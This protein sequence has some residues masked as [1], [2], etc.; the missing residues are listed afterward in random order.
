ME[1]AV[2]IAKNDHLNYCDQNFSRLYFG[3]E[4]CPHLLPAPGELAAVL[5]FARD[6]D[7][8]LVTPTSPTRSWAG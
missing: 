4:F 2:F 7:F 3:N 6:R 1:Y 8:S 5:E